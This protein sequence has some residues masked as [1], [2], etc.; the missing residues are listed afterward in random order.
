MH[1]TNN[2]IFA[3]PPEL[4]GAIRDGIESEINV[5]NLQPRPCLFWGAVL[6]GMQQGL[7]A[8]IRNQGAPVAP[9]HRIIEGI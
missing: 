7:N 2:I 5:H 8:G 6:A 4:F 3:K 1:I 9:L